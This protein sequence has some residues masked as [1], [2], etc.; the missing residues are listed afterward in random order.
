MKLWKTFISVIFSYKVST[1]CLFIVRKLFTCSFFIFQYSFV[2]LRNYMYKK[3]P[4]PHP[5]GKVEVVRSVSVRMKVQSP[6]SACHYMHMYMYTLH[7]YINWSSSVINRWGDN[8][9]F[10]LLM[11]QISATNTFSNFSF[12]I[13]LQQTLKIKGKSWSFG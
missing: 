9:Q 2:S 13:S 6:N 4:P 3:H 11:V 5:F 1:L 7:P 12:G 8:P 10:Q